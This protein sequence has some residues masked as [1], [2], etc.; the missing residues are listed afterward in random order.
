MDK[1]ILVF[2]NGEKI[3]DGIIKLQLLHEIKSRLSDYKL[4]FFI[5]AIKLFSSS[6]ITLNLTTLINFDIKIFIPYFSI[7]FLFSLVKSHF[8]LIKNTY[9]MR[10]NSNQQFSGQLIIFNDRAKL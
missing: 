5:A 1:K 8:E 2:S 4:Y 9:I 10:I 7:L 3:G 6:V